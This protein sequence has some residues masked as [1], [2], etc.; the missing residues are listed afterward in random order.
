VSN[1]TQA[2]A[3]VV[4]ETIHIWM[5][6]TAAISTILAIPHAIVT[7]MLELPS[8]IVNLHI[9]ITLGFWIAGIVF[10]TSRPKQLSAGTPAQPKI[11]ALPLAPELRK[12]ISE[13]DALEAWLNRT[14]GNER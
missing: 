7:F 4:P 12:T 8:A 1:Q 10:A 13:V 3:P 5:F 6:A 11:E 2:P 14:D 9:A